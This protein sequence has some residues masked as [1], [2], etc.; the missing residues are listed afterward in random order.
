MTD[1]LC[2][3]LNTLRRVSRKE[4]LTVRHQPLD[5]LDVLPLRLIVEHVRDVLRENLCGTERLM[6]QLLYIATS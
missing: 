1:T 5:T 6:S 3:V 2:V 4:S